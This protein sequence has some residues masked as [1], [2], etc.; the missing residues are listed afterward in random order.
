M[1]QATP[2]PP[3]SIDAGF[4]RRV[5]ALARLRIDD[6]ELPALTDQFQRILGLV[7]AV[8]A[9]DVPL[10]AGSHLPPLTLEQLRPDEPGPTLARRDITRNAP[11]HDGAFLVVPRFRGDEA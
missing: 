2:P 3:P 5:A 11:A 8:A 6:A 10:E 7:G 9:L 4:V 1:S